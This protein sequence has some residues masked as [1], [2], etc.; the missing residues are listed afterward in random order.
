MLDGEPDKMY[1]DTFDLCLAEV[2]KELLPELHKVFTCRG[3]RRLDAISVLTEKIANKLNWKEV[4]FLQ[5]QCKMWDMYHKPY[6]TQYME[7]VNLE[8]EVARLNEDNASLKEANALL[9]LKIADIEPTSD[10]I[11]A[12]DG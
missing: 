8:K 1:S 3:E 11:Q 5:Y 4:R 12:N 7:I 10:V 6:M 9:N 2:R